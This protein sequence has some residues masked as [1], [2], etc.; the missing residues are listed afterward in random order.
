M[1]Q[2]K[3]QKSVIVYTL[4][5]VKV[6]LRKYCRKYN[7]ESVKK[8]ILLF[9]SCFMLENACYNLLSY[10]KRKFPIE[11]LLEMFPSFLMNHMKR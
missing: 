9:L 4:V 7:T 1:F 11:Y 2:T 6:S 10:S 8:I 3:P 5:K